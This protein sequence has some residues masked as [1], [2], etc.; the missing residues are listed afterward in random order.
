MTCQGVARGSAGGGS[1]SLES[2]G[3]APPQVVLE[4]SKI[5]RKI[6]KKIEKPII[7]AYFSKNFKNTALVFRAMDETQMVENVLRKFFKFLMQIQ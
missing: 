1:A 6:L 7:L 2:G 4:F 3:R 5:C